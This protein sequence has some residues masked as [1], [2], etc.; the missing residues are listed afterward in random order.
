MNCPSCGQ[1]LEPGF[2]R[3][4]R[5]GYEL[6]GGDESLP[7]MFPEG[8]PPEEPADTDAAPASDERKWWQI[9]RPR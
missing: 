1:P 3:C 8:E 5:C 2:T 9:W 7:H 6:V 4:F